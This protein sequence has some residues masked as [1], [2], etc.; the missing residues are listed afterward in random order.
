M[1]E[2]CKECPEEKRKNC[3]ILRDFFSRDDQALHRTVFPRAY[4]VALVANDVPDGDLCFSLYGWKQGLITPRGFY[5]GKGAELR[6]ELSAV[7]IQ[8]DAVENHVP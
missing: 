2:W 5:I 4:S 7:P 1:R 8:K 6:Q 3:S